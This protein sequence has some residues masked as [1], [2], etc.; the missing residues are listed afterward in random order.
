LQEHFDLKINF[1]LMVNFVFFWPNNFG[2][3]HG[4]SVKC[5]LWTFHKLLKRQKN[6]DNK[7]LLLKDVMR[8]L[9]K[10]LSFCYI[11]TTVNSEKARDP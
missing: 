2:M 3:A 1:D 7:L 5:S 11:H 10:T 6:F 9:I 8:V 4:I